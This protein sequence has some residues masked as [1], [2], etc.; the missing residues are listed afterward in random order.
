M[1]DSSLVVT[2]ELIRRYDRPCPR[3]TSYPTADRFHEGFDARDAAAALA[4]TDSA[5][6]SAPLSL[7][8]HLPFCAKLCTY[9]GCTVVV[10]KDEDKKR[11]YLDRV[12]L[13]V[14]LAASQ[15][16]RGRPVKEIHLGGG[17]PNSYPPEELARLLAHLEER[18]EVAPDAEISIEIDPRHANER[19]A[20]ELADIGFGR[21]SMGV[22]DFEPRVQEAIGRIQTYGRTAAAIGA[23]RAAGFRSVNLDLVYGLPLQTRDSFARTVE[24]TLALAPDRIALFSFA[25]VPDVRPQQKKIPRAALPPA[26]EK[27]AMFCD[28]RAALIEA[29]Y[30]AIGM[31]HFAR[32]DDP[33]AIAERVGTLHR[34]FQGYTVLR[35]ADL[36]GFGMSA[37][38]D[39]GGAYWQNAKKLV[40]YDEAVDRGRLPVERGF[41]LSRDDE[42]RRYIIRELMCSFRVRDA[43]VRARYGVSLEADLVPEMDRISDRE[44]EGLAVRTA[45]GI[46]VTEL[47]RLF[48]RVVASAFDRYL[49]EARAAVTYSRAV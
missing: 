18:F 43:D 21:L 9:C 44:I 40:R 2:P 8:V 32:P 17:T 46:E 35:G 47:G 48:V 23:A 49:H 15:L 30:V 37:I 33:L 10:S 29:G 25:Y 14:D 22:Q 38:S 19:L 16:T 1:A 4:R 27:L 6:A 41:A 34:N 24:Q 11:S 42:A 36:L 31:D 13:E 39:A 26:G 12:L 5:D 20:F 45:D 3:Y 7:Y 28:A